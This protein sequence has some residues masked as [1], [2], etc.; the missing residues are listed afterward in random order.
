MEV[1]LKLI[2]AYH[3]G[4]R[5]LSLDVGIGAGNMLRE[6]SLR[7][8][9]VYGA[10]F[11]SSIVR[12]CRERLREF[13]YEIAQR[14]TQADVEALQM[15]SDTF[16]LV[17]CLGV[18]EYLLTDRKAL[19]EIYRI[20]RPGGYLILAVASYHRIGYIFSLARDR[21]LG[22]SGKKKLCET[23]VLDYQVRLIKPTD[24]RGE[25]KKAGFEVKDF[26]CF[27]GRIFGRY[28][29]MRFYVPG[30][31]YIGDHCLLVLRKPV[32]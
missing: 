6:L 7:G 3:L 14:I 1:A 22:R 4:R 2:D 15:E 5:G 8:S 26:R 30:L 12:Y 21:V 17:T 11:S 23:A 25:A 24:L 31:I 13:D 32:A 27:G 29:P 18:F 20:L 16:D 10:D 9:R 28:F 19:A